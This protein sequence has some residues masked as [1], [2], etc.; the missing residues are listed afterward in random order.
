VPRSPRS[1][2]ASRPRIVPG[3]RSAPTSRAPICSERSLQRISGRPLPA[4]SSVPM[5]RRSSPTSSHSGARRRPRPGTDVCSSSSSSSPMSRSSPSRR[6]RRC[7]RRRFPTPRSPC[8]T[9]DELK[10]LLKACEV[11]AAVLESLAFTAAGGA[12]PTRPE[13]LRAA[14]ATNL[15]WGLRVASWAS[16]SP[17]G[18][19]CYPNR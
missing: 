11:V 10:R 15:L 2:G 4:K 8:F 17:S 6:W 12:R 7:R 13:R 16:A 1:A 18:E 3:R 19:C 14:N 5:S 9:P